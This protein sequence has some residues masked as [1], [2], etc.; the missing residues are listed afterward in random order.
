MVQEVLVSL[1]FIIAIS[2]LFTIIAKL[3]KQPPIIAYLIVGVLVGP[4]FLNLV[5]SESLNQGLIQT[6]ARIGVAFLLFIVGLHLDFRILKE[7]GKTSI[8]AGVLEIIVVG[9]FGGLIGFFLGFDI[10]SSVYLGLIIAFSSTVVVVKI[11]SDKKQIETL[12]GRMSLGILIIQDI[13]AAIFLMLLPFIVDFNGNNNFIFKEI[14]IAAFII[15][16][17]FI[18]ANLVFKKIMNYLAKSQEALFL[19]GIAWALAIATIFFELGFSLEIGALIA[20]MSLASSRYS[21]DLSGKMK[22][23]RDFFMVLFF[24]YF[25]S[26]LAGNISLTLLLNTLIIAVFVILLKPVLIMLILK[27]FHFTKKTNFLTSICLAQ[28]SEFSLILALLGFNLGHIGREVINLS[29]LVSLVTIAFSS[30]FINYSDRLT[31]KLLGFLNFFES[32]KLIS[33]NK[34][35]KEKEYDIILFGYH[36]IGFK[37][38]Q[39]IKKLGKSFLVVDYNPKVILA[40]EEEKIECLFGDAGNKNFLEDLPLEKARLVISTI[41]DQE[42]TLTLLEAIKEKNS[43]AAII[44]TVEQPRDAHYLYKEGID[45]VIIPHHL[46]GDFANQL[47][48]ELGTDKAKYIQKGKKHF[49][50]LDS[51]KISSGFD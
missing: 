21:Y 49:K 45:Y 6:F 47:I 17:I 34:E 42:T 38:L 10:I 41:P 14:L 15:F 31:R 13:I 11:L 8:F 43:N 32:K 37:L 50:E 4:V 29:I 27:F 28:I 46:G 33:E 7:I 35:I 5:N 25:G 1:S 9:F 40:L 22:P 18:F 2:A 16:G 23:L 36:R 26:Q 48:R 44:A 3:I 12:H 30:Y 19:F 20:G 51:A 39:T 24:V